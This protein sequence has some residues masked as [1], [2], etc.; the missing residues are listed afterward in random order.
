MK[1]NMAAVLFISLLTQISLASAETFAVNGAA[2]VYDPLGTEFSSTPVTGEYDTDANSITIDPWI[3]FGSPVN[4][5][6]DVLPP[7][8]YSFPGV[9][10]FEVQAGQSGGLMSIDWNANTIPNGIVWDVTPYPGGQHFE[11]FDSDGDGIPGQQMISGPF[12]GFTFVYEFD[13]GVPG[14]SID[15]SIGITGGNNQQCDEIGGTHVELTAAVDLGGGAVLDSIEWTVDGN[16]AGSGAAITP[17]LSLGTHAVSVTAFSTL[18]IADTA[19]ANVN[20]IDTV[21]PELRIEFIDRRSGEVVTSVEGP[22]T[23]FIEIRLA[24]TDACDGEVEVTGVAK[25]TFV[26]QGGE[27]IRIQGRNQEVEMP[28]SAI[29]VTATATDDSG[30]Q[31]LGQAILQINN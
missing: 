30:N 19:S 3:F 31:K 5:L 24:G 7:G 17:F 4:T 15:V 29:E 22:R 25:P 10:P 16:P 26:V 20:V 6:I 13:A 8:V 23:S 12:P 18:G 9:A 1:R 2:K 28:T 21:Q 14:P 27:V 11:P